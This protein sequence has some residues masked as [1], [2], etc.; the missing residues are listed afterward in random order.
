MSLDALMN[1]T[2]WDAA[3]LQAQLMELEL[4]GQIARLPGGMYQRISHS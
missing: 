3:Q 2:G 1:R 4:D